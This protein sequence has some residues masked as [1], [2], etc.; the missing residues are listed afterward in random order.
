M[1]TGPELFCAIATFIA[2]ASPA[3]GSIPNGCASTAASESPLSVQERRNP[4][5]RPNV[6]LETLKDVH[7]L[8]ELCWRANLPP[9]VKA[10]PGMTVTV[11]VSFTQTGEVLGEPVFTFVTKDVPPDTRMLYQRA[12]ASALNTCTP[13]PFSETL[14]NAIAGQPRIFPLTDRR[15]EKR[16]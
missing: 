13:M 2:L 8:M 10:W 16:T 12:A 11:R 6:K 1:R 14:G 3:S 7:L 9:N 5:L 15:N 4:R